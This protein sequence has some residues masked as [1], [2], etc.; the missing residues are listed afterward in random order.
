MSKLSTGRSRFEFAKNRNEN[1]KNQVLIPEYVLD[2][3]DK[4]IFLNLYIITNKNNDNEVYNK[5]FN[6]NWINI[7]FGINQSFVKN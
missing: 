7:L 4:S 2:L 6:D 3:L 1:L 5:N